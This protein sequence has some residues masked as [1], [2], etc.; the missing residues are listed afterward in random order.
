MSKYFKN[1]KSYNELKS[2]YKELLKANHPDNG[3]DLAKM[4]EINAEYDALF[5]ILSK[6]KQSD[7]QSY[8]YEENE[9]FKAIM[10]EI[11]GFNMTVEII[12]S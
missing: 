3:G 7:S 1:V 5:A 4:Q 8:T 11:I 10:N 9:Q 2:T 6:E 12:G